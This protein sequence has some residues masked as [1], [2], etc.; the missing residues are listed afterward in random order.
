MDAPGAVLPPLMPREYLKT[1]NPPGQRTFLC[2]TAPFFLEIRQYSC[3]KMSCS[4]RKSL[5]A[6]HIFSFQIHPSYST[7]GQFTGR[8]GDGHR[9]ENPPVLLVQSTK[10]DRQQN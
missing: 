3:G 4:A 2:C 9:T 7:D 6:G 10:R 5:A 8:E 1:A